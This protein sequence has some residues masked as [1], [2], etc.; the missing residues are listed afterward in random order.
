MRQYKLLLLLSLILFTA[1]QEEEL[2]E[3]SNEKPIFALEG[4]V[5]EQRRTL[6]AGQEEYY[7]HSDFTRDSNN[8]FQ[9][10]GHLGPVQ[11]RDCPQSLKIALPAYRKADGSLNLEEALKPG[12]HEFYNPEPVFEVKLTAIPNG[13]GDAQFQWDFGDKRTARQKAPTHYYPANGQGSYKARLKTVYDQGACVRTTSRTIALDSQDCRANF[14]VEPVNGR[15]VIFQSQVQKLNPPVDYRWFKD[16]TLISKVADPTHDF[17]EPGLYEVCLQAT[18]ASGCVATRCRK[19]DVFDKGCNAN[20]RYTVADEVQSVD[21]S[22]INITWWDAE[23]KRYETGKQE[24]PEASY[25]RIVEAEPY[26]ENREGQP[27]HRLK[28]EFDCMVYSENDRKRLN[29]FKGT[30]AVAHPTLTE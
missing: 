19:V 16:S 23:G 5:D 13:P 21:P 9:L 27:T 7:M 14:T 2:P 8:R 30:V 22:F 15:E 26:Q 10:I 12:E 20:F 28:V 4:T 6:T 11:C 18:G 17:N 29:G 25:F 3:A 24:Q 1:C